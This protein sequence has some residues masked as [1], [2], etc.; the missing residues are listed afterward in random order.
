MD[1]LRSV[2]KTMSNV[3]VLFQF[4]LEITEKRSILLLNRNINY[5]SSYCQEQDFLLLTDLFSSDM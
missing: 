2:P 4:W 5:M 1:Q 3:T